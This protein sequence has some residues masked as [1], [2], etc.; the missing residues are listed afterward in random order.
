MEKTQFQLNNHQVETEFLKRQEV[1]TTLS[2]NF[3][4]NFLEEKSHYQD[5]K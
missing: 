3:S 4:W 5:C 1:E 2:L